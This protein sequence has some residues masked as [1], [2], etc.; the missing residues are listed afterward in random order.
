MKGCAGKIVENVV[1]CRTPAKILF[2]EDSRIRTPNFD[3]VN[4]DNIVSYNFRH[5]YP[6]LP[7]EHALSRGSS[8]NNVVTDIHE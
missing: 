2:S 8:N 7:S 4:S 1:D 6:C 5:I 3:C